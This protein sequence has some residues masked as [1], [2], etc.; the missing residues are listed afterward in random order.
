MLIYRRDATNTVNM[1]KQPGTD[2]VCPAVRVDPSVHVV[3]ARRRAAVGGE[4]LCDLY[5]S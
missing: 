2:K 4:R 5:E 3:V 1:K